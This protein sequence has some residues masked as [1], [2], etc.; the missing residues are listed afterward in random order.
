VTWLWN[1]QQNNAVIPREA[2]LPHAVL[3]SRRIC[4]CFSLN[5]WLAILVAEVFAWPFIRLFKLT[6]L[7]HFQC[8]LCPEV[9][10]FLARFF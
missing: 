8:I 5:L 1:P 10:I 4:S 2:R 9:P 7:H 6:N 3:V